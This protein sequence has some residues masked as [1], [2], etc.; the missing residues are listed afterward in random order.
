[1]TD[2][3][4][5]RPMPKFLSGDRPQMPRE[6]PVPRSPV[7]DDFAKRIME[8]LSEDP[9]NR[10]ADMILNLTYGKMKEL[11]KGLKVHAGD[12]NQLDFADILHQWSL[13]QTKTR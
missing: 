8:P 4:N 12:N 1:M 9:L 6:V 11:D 7:S 5:L 2:T 3:D 13:E 10:I